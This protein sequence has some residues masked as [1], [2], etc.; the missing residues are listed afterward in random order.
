MQHVL[1]DTMARQVEQGCE[2][3]LAAARSEVEGIVTEARE[4]AAK[5]YTDTIERTKRD[6]ERHAQR[7]RELAALQAGQQAHSMKQAVADE[8]LNSVAAALARVAEGP[9]FPGILEVLLSEIMTVAPPQAEVLAPPA[10]IER[11]RQWLA[12]NGHAGTPV[13]P[14]DAL[15]DGVAVQDTQRSFRIT[16]SLSS[17]FGKLENEAREVCLRLL[18]G[19]GAE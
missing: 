15:R 9:E 7:V 3:R 12:S 4:R 19:E 5:R 13:V 8:I 14:N 10:H 17:R 2:Q 6:V 16:N 1:L 11:C 18:F